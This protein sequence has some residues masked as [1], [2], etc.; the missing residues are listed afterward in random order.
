CHFP[1]H[2]VGLDAA[3]NVVPCG[4]WYGEEPMGNIRTESFEEIWTGRRFRALRAEHQA[5]ER[6]P[7]CRNCP[8][9]GVGRVSDAG[10]F[11]VVDTGLAPRPD[12]PSPSGAGRRIPLS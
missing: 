2:F 1:W 4:W 10:A 3:G 7:T 12:V 9:M 11:A 6:R 5:G 8:A